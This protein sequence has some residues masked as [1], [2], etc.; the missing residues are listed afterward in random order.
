MKDILEWIVGMINIIP[1]KKNGT[2]GMVKRIAEKRNRWQL[3]V[4]NLCD[5]GDDN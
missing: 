4:V 1:V 2:Y 5:D 3:I